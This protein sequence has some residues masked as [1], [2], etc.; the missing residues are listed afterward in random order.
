MSLAGRTLTTIILCGLLPGAAFA[1]Q[2]P[3]PEDR[4]APDFDIREQTPGRA[5]V[6]PGVEMAL[7]RLRASSSA[8]LEVRYHPLTGG[9]R[10]AWNVFLEPEGFPQAYETLVDATTGQVLYRRNTYNYA[11]G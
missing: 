6:P 11:E 1:V 3:R 9:A 5:A 2:K 10:L 8:G 4:V 7:E